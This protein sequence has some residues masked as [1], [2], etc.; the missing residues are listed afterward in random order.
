MAVT[1]EERVKAAKALYERGKAMNKDKTYTLRDIT[2]EEFVLLGKM[3]MSETISSTD[4]KGNWYNQRFKQFNEMLKAF[5]VLAEFKTLKPKGGEYSFT[6]R[7]KTFI[8]M[9]FRE[10][11]K[12][13]LS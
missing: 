13:F 4:S 6:K 2:D 12:S 8:M 11:N 1:N 7:N 5:D 3:D 9:L 10:Y